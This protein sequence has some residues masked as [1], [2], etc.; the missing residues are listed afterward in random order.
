MDAERPRWG[1]HAERGNEKS[2]SSVV[3]IEQA[4]KQ[5]GTDELAKF[6]TWFAEYDAEIWDRQFEA[7]AAAGRL[8]FLKDEAL[9]D[10]SE[11]KCVDL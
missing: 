9:R 10:L 4:V 7:D 5:L 2:M 11:G 6:R 8:D 3:E 1:P